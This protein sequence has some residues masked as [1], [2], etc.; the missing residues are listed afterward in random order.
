MPPETDPEVRDAEEFHER[1]EDL[2]LRAERNGIDVQ[3]SWPCFNGT[4]A[5]SWDVEIVEIVDS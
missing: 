2:L 4:E 1:L 3:G 5:P